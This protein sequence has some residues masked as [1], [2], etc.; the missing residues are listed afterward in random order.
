MPLTLRISLSYWQS[1][2]SVPL[3]RWPCLRLD[4]LRL[5]MSILTS[6]VCLRGDRAGIPQGLYRSKLL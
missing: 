1:E 2:P 4:M 6:C 3:R 5:V